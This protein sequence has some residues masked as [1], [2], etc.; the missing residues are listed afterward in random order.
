MIPSDDSELARATVAQ[1]MK[2]RRQMIKELLDRLDSRLEIIAALVA[3]HCSVNHLNFINGDPQVE[4]DSMAISANADAM[5]E[6]AAQGR[7][8]IISEHGRR[9]L[10][11]WRRPKSTQ[12]EA[13]EPGAERGAKAP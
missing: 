6:L 4:L 11:K 3:Q 12:N 7:I 1:I 5:R 2:A 8:E 9:I 13:D 10:A